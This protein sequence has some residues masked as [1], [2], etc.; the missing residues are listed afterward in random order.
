MI[1]LSQITEFL[2]WASIINMGF[3]LVVTICLIFMKDFVTSTHSRLFNI[4]EEELPAIYFNYLANY[5]T[6]SLI[7]CVVPYISLKLMGT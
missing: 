7:L 1:T 2:G 5:K 4:S 6:L 3:L